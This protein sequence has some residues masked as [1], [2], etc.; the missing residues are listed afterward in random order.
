MIKVL[1]LGDVFGRPGRRLAREL[2]P[3]LVARHEIDLVAANVENAAGG[4]GLSI[5]AAEELF[6]AGV[7]VMTSGNHIWR[8]KE[9]YDFLESDDRI[10]RPANYPDS[11]PGRGSLIYRTAGGV[12]VGVVN[13]IGR[14]FMKPLACPF[15]LANREVG[16]LKEAGVRVILVDMHAE[17]T[18]EK[19]ALGWHLDGR[20]GAVLGTHTHV[21]T[22]D[23]EILPGGT[24]YLTDLGMTG[25]HES[26]IGMKKEG[27]LSGFLTSLPIRFEAAKR[28]LR[29]EGAIIFLDPETGRA[30]NI[31]RIQ[32]VM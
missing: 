14:V 15:E 13:L 16:R 32:E 1:F 25:P 21:Q 10:V 5:K 11:A 2:L 27:I 8:H 26:V 17:A 31:E 18:S 30:K 28:G 9:I 4:V 12:D 3:S 29:L 19:R 20:V 23:E 7:D 24:A 22:A 6:E